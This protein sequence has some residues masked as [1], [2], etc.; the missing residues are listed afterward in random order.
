[1]S[2]SSLPYIYSPLRNHDG[3]RLLRIVSD[4]P[5]HRR[6]A[7]ETPDT[8]LNIELE[9]FCLSEQNE[10]RCLSYTWGSSVVAYT[11]L[12]NG[13]TLPITANLKSALEALRGF[14]GTAWVWVD[15]ICINQKDDHE[16]SHQVRQMRNIYSK[17]SEVI[18][19]LG[20]AANR[21]EEIPLCIDGIIQGVEHWQ[22]AHEWG[23]KPSP[24]PEQDY[25]AYE[26]A[27]YNNVC[28]EIIKVFLTRPWFTRIW[29]IQEAV[30]ARELT[31]ICGDWALPAEIILYFAE[32]A[33]LHNLP[34]GQSSPHHA[35]KGLTQLW[36]MTQLTLNGFEKGQ[37]NN[38]RFG[39]PKADLLNLMQCM[40][41][42]RAS[43]PHDNVFALFGISKE[44]KVNELQP[45]YVQS[46]ADTYRRCASY[47]IG[48][49]Q[50]CKVL[51]HIQFPQSTVDLPSWVPDWGNRKQEYRSLVS[52]PL[53]PQPGNKEPN[54]GGTTTCKMHITLCDKRLVAEAYLIDSVKSL[55]TAAFRTKFLQNNSDVFQHGLHGLKHQESLED[56]ATALA[57]IS[58]FLEENE[59]YTTK[60]VQRE[61]LWRT[62]LCNKE[63]GYHNEAPL[64]YE[65]LLD[66]YLSALKSTPFA[67]GPSVKESLSRICTCL[68]ANKTGTVVQVPRE[69]GRLHEQTQYFHIMAAT[70]SE[71]R[72][73]IRTHKGYVGQVPICAQQRDVVAICAGARIP[74]L[75][76]PQGHDSYSI[77]GQCYLYGFMNGEVLSMAQHKAQ[78]V[79]IV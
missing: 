19:H 5:V 68:P 36:M 72:K 58:S 41:C 61:V 55:G 57:E 64:H 75:L 66:D 77:I 28:W 62:I 26:I 3:I 35:T 45:D 27:P 63:F 29:I 48:I 6:R 21:S 73:R 16:R 42:Q 59:V 17:A 50:G 8:S 20:E 38:N 18:A 25:V 39:P 15:A 79:A 12:V 1:M 10:Y 60:E 9:E 51:E 54:A 67:L 14:V 65:N 33:I 49:G 13:K 44:Y 2:D 11:L 74:I 30:L 71:G 78:E 43:D 37:D 47:F 7:G 70:Q 56:L 52:E 4:K 53:F 32:L 31:F 34:L 22:Q 23:S 76:R 40:E 46:V 69:V 24:I